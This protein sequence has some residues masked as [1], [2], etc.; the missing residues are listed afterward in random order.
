MMQSNRTKK[1]AAEVIML[2]KA[3]I[4]ARAGGIREWFTA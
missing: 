3:T 4:Y 1:I 2:M